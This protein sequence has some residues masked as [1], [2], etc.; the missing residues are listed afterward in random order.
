MN[1]RRPISASA[2]CLVR[3]LALL[4]LL[5]GDPPEDHHA[6]AGEQHR[7]AVDDRPQ[8]RARLA[9]RVVEDQVAC[10]SR[11]D[12]VAEHGEDDV[13]EERHPVL[14][15]RDEA[16]DDEEV[17][18]RLDRAVGQ[19]DQRRRAVGE[20]G[21]DRD[22]GRSPRAAERLPQPEADRRRDQHE[23]GRGKPPA[24]EDAERGEPGQV[25]AKQP[26]QESVPARP[27]RIVEGV[28]ARQV[29][30]QPFHCLHRGL[31]HPFYA[32]PQRCGSRPN[33]A[34]KDSESL[35]RS[36][37]LS[38]VGERAFG[39]PYTHSHEHHTSGSA[40]RPAEGGWSARPE[41]AVAPSRLDR[42]IAHEQHCRAAD[43]AAPGHG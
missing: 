16:D 29:A 2:S 40:Y 42:L 34:A 26:L 39:E 18:V 36:S 19:P 28:T 8:P 6:D 38:T 23:Q 32:K 33:G 22:L 1:R 41:R 35:G 7:D 14:V 10:H 24:Q 25:Q 4:L 30:Q 43:R 13:P 31:D 17:E 11:A 15:E 9:G 3:R 20:P 37:Q 5:L 21:G 27:R 12:A